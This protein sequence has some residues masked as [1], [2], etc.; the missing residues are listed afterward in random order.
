MQIKLLELRTKR[1]TGGRPL[2]LRAVSEGTG[3][4]LRT[5]EN[6]STGNIKMWR[7]EYIDALCTFFECTPGDL[8]A[9]DVVELPMSLVLRPDRRGKPVVPSSE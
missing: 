1:G 7:A 3:I 5:M 8:I 2:S 9:A 6:I 4:D